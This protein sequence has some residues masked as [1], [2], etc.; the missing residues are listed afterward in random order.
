MRGTPACLCSGLCQGGGP[1][2]S[3]PIY[4]AQSRALNSRKFMQVQASPLCGACLSSFFCR[5]TCL[6]QLYTDI[7]AARLCHLKNISYFHSSHHIVKCNL[8]ALRSSKSHQKRAKLT[9]CT[10]DTNRQPTKTSH[11]FQNACTAAQ[12]SFLRMESYCHL[13]SGGTSKSCKIWQYQLHIGRRLSDSSL[14]RRQ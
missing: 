9:Y 14:P 4:A 1:T 7:M 2:C 12:F 10:Q 3:P 13:A 6:L 11:I 5:Y 8:S